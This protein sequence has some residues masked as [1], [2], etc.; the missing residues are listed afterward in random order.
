MIKN[1]TVIKRMISKGWKPVLGLTALVAAITGVSAF[2]EKSLG[3]DF[4]TVYWGLYLAV[5]VGY[6]LKTAYDWQRMELKWEQEKMMRDLGKK[7]D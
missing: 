7:N 6:G 3:W 5:F 4:D 1:S 2:A